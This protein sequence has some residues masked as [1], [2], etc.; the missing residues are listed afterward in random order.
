MTI[1]I[2]IVK[3]IY[4]KCNDIDS[5]LLFHKIW[6][7]SIFFTKRRSLNFFNSFSENFINI[8]SSILRYKATRIEL[9]QIINGSIIRY[10]Y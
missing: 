9:I 7:S 2:E 4:D 8:L 3:I 6:D 1:P 10:Q 5:K